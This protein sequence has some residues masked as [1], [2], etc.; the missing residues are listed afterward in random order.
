MGRIIMFPSEAPL[1]GTSRAFGDLVA[2]VVDRANC[3]DEF[4]TRV[5]GAMS[6]LSSGWRYGDPD[7]ID[8]DD[9]NGGGERIA[10]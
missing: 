5:L 6:L 8:P 10:A 3:G 9:G 2:D 1:S 4:A 7:P